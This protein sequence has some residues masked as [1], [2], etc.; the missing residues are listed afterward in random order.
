MGAGTFTPVRVDD[1]SEHQMHGEWYHISVDA[2]SIIQSA[3]LEGRRIFA[4]GTTT[5]RCLEGSAAVN[6]GQIRAGSSET[7]IFITPGYKFNVID[8]LFTNFHL[9]EST[10]LNARLRVWGF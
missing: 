8:V 10:L 7:S 9:P 1:L 3:K 5:M 6:G 2:E 4:I